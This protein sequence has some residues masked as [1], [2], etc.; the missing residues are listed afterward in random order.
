[1]ADTKRSRIGRTEA[2]PERRRR[3]HSAAFKRRIVKLTLEPGASVAAIALEHGLNTNL[4][5]KWRRQYLRYLAKATGA[6][7]ALLPVTI[8]PTAKRIAPVVRDVDVTPERARA[9]GCIELELPGGRVRLEGGV[10]RD[11]LRLVVHL[12]GGR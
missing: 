9:T 8:T 10:D 4:V 6:E 1:M 7:P 12:L 2:R 5:F 11:T 3:A